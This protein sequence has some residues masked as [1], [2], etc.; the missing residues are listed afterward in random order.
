MAVLSSAF[1]S[2]A[3]RLEHRPRT[4]DELRVAMSEMRQRGMTD[5]GI[6]QATGLAVEAVRSLL[7]IPVVKDAP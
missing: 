3:R 5:Y 2:D 4:R 7:G 6:A 1:D